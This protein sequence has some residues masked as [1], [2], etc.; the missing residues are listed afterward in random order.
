[1]NMA[2]FVVSL[3]G[4]LSVEMQLIYTVKTLDTLYAPSNA[5]KST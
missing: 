3:V 4:V 2:L 5:S 1:M